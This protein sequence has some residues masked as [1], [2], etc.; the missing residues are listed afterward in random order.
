MKKIVA[1]A[2]LLAG[3][4]CAQAQTEQPRHVDFTKELRGFDGKP[5]MNGD[6]K[7]P[8]PMTLG[9][10]AVTALDTPIDTDRGEAG[11]AKFKRDELA[12]KIYHQKSVVLTVEEMAT[13]KERIGKYWGPVVVGAAWPLLDPAQK[14][15]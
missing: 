6:P 7:S 11:D 13:I 3:S 9:D 10:A 15:E 5:I 2:V 4:L 14:K 1:I 8:E 12:R